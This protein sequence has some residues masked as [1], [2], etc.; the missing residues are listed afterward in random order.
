MLGGSVLHLAGSL[1]RWQYHLASTVLPAY[2]CFA[3]VQQG[4]PGNTEH[5]VVY[6]LR[7][8]ELACLTR[9]CSPFCMVLRRGRVC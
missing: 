2:K 3:V 5:R 7:V 4:E 6:A 8:D 9:H 1:V